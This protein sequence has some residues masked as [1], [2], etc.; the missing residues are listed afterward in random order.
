[1][2]NF[3]LLNGTANKNKMLLRNKQSTGFVTSLLRIQRRSSGSF[4]LHHIRA[5]NRAVILGFWKVW[6]FQDRRFSPH[7][8]NKPFGR[9]FYPKCRTANIWSLN[10]PGGTWTL[11]PDCVSALLLH[12]IVSL[13]MKS[14][15]AE[16]S[17]TNWV[18]WWWE[19]PLAALKS[20]LMR[21]LFGEDEEIKRLFLKQL[22]RC[23]YTHII[24][25][26]FKY[27]CVHQ[28]KSKSL[29]SSRSD[30]WSSA[31]PLR[32]QKSSNQ[33]DFYSLFRSPL[34]CTAPVQLTHE[35]QS[36]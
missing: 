19:S 6:N 5:K 24:S 16:L 25:Y 26:Y 2:I 7:S 8:D 32:S 14:S 33:S 13:N 29:P 15:S 28:I 23:K 17:V 36:Q 20:L 21:L 3:L 1:M 12:F 34:S 9:C 18:S 10:R 11:N 31:F 35:K 4:K 30:G 22:R 27:F